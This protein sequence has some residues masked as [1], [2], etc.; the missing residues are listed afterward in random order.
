MII[1]EH[2]GIL[3]IQTPQAAIRKVQQYFARFDN[4][5][6]MSEELL[7]DR[8]AEAA[9]EKSSHCRDIGG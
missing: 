6:R 4:G 3:H 8:K 9:R 2:D 1:E 5:R 7:R